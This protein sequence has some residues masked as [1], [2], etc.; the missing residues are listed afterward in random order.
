MKSIPL[1]IIIALAIVFPLL[2]GIAFIYYSCR[3]SKPK[4]KISAG[5]EETIQKTSDEYSSIFDEQ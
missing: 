2:V 4:D 1:Q 5:D 3:H